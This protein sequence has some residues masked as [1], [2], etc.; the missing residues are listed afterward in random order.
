MHV[1]QLLECHISNFRICCH[2]Y[3]CRTPPS[4]D[5]YFENNI[6]CS[7]ITFLDKTLLITWFSKIC[8]LVFLDETPWSSNPL[9]QAT[10]ASCHG[11][12]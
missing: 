6:T 8:Q 7:I 3:H 9:V 1:E 5:C 10:L 2:N 11:A 12:R 4:S